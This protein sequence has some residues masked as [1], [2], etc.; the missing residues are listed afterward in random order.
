MKSLQA[1]LLVNSSLALGEGLQQSPDKEIHCVDIP[2]GK[3]FVLLENSLVLE[4]SFPH[5]VS[6]ILPWEFGQL[7]LGRDFIHQFDW[8][9]NEVG[10]IAVCEPDSNLRCSDGC[11][12]PDGSLLVGIVD[13][14][15]AAGQGSLLRITVDLSIEVMIDGATIPNGVAVMPNGNSVVW[16]D[17]PKQKLLLFPIGEDSSLGE[18]K[19]LFEIPKHLGIPDGL[20]VDQAG[21]IWVA[22]WAGGKVIRVSETREIDFEISVDCQNVTSCAFDS[23]G[24]LLI[25]TASVALPEADAG[26]AGAGG[27]WVCDLSEFGFSGIESFVSKVRHS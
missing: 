2:N 8:K 9:G 1:Q 3:T 26:K 18:P 5:E 10:R 4:K 14:G 27:I 16:V 19:E 15:L 7:V 21:G 24:R 13:R 22:L 25:T 23:A 11:V 17:S 20:T 6:K 12:L